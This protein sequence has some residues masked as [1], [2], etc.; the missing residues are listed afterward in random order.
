MEECLHPRLL[1]SL[2]RSG[3]HPSATPSLPGLV[4]CLPRVFLWEG[5]GVLLV[6]TCHMPSAVQSQDAGLPCQLWARLGSVCSGP[7]GLPSLCELVRSLPPLDLTPC[8]RSGRLAWP[9]HLPVVVSRCG[10][11]R[12]VP[13]RRR[14]ETWSLKP[15]LRETFGPGGPGFIRPQ[16]GPVQAFGSSSLRC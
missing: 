13:G 3:P 10:R 12:D 2:S 6:F 1:A 15:W 8:S 4:V 11:S 16:L 5:G 14:C 7:P 9:P